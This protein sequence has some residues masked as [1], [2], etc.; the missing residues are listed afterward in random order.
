[1]WKRQASGNLERVKAAVS[2]T[3]AAGGP[4]AV[5]KS[6]CQAPTTALAYCV[7]SSGEEVLIACFGPYVRMYRK[8]GSSAVATLKVRAV[9]CTTCDCVAQA[10]TDG[11]IHGIC[12]LA[13]GLVILHGQKNVAVLRIDSG[14]G[15][16]QWVD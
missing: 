16:L 9:V 15:P 6:W 4:L 8:G 13:K 2:S 1:M 7:S 12:V 5:T 14:G 3:W 11:T 10:W